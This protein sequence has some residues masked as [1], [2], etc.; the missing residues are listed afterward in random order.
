MKRLV[1]VAVILSLSAC[2]SIKV[3]YDYDKQANFS[4]YKTYAFSEDALNLP[5]DQLNRDRVI[6]AIET[7]MAAKGFTKSDS[8]DLLVD[9]QVATEENTTATA[10]STDMGGMYGGYGRYGGRYGYGGGFST[11]QINYNKYVDGTLF[12]NLVDAQTQ[13]IAW[14]GHGTKTLDENASAEKREENINYAIKRIFTNYPPAT[15]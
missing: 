4:N 8:P 13:K 12:I 3:S 5:V 14:Q 6:K 10:T 15:K 11:T 9:L 7:E 2:S 1:F